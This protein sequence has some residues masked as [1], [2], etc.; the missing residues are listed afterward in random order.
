M[1]FKTKSSDCRHNFGRTR[2]VARFKVWRGQIHFYGGKIL[3]F[4]ICL[5]QIFLST[6]KFGGHKKNLGVTATE[7]LTVSAGL[8]R[9]VARKSSIGGLHVCAGGFDILK[10]YC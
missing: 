8:S 3:I 4:I 5:K 6:T 7:C 1:A 10:N 9:T 2:P